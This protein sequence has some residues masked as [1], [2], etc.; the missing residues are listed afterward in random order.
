MQGPEGAVHTRK[1]RRLARCALSSA[2]ITNTQC[3]TTCTHLP[4]SDSITE[5]NEMMYVGSKNT[6]TVSAPSLNPAR[7]NSEALVY[8]HIATP[9][10]IA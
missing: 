6:R 3:F 4:H 7:D 8:S 5:S 2:M 1:E 9:S 10:L